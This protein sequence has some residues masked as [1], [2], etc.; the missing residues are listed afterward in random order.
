MTRERPKR[1]P[2]ASRKPPP[3]Y[4]ADPNLYGDPENWKYPLDTP[5]RAKLARRFFSMERSRRKYSKEERVYIDSR[6]SSAL[7]GFGINPEEFMGAA[8]GSERVPDIVFP[9]NTD[10]D[11]LSLDELLLHFIGKKR[12]QSSRSIPTDRVKIEKVTDEYIVA[13]VKEYVIKVDLGSRVFAHDCGDWIAWMS[14]K[15]M[16]KHVAKLLMMIDQEVAAGIL[17][18]LYGKK[19]EWTFSSKPREVFA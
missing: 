2:G 9:D 8:K 14:K 1:R 10:P 19:S 11:V 13:R 7:E 18:D 16:C 6:I 4:P 15:L 17:R 12:I 3:G 5:R